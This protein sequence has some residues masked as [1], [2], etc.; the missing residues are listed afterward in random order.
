MK[1]WVKGHA[2]RYP[3]VRCYG[4]N[5]LAGPTVAKIDGTR[6]SWEWLQDVRRF[7]SDAPMLKILNYL[8]NLSNKTGILVSGDSERIGGSFLFPSKPPLRP[9]TNRY[10]GHYIGSVTSAASRYSASR[11]NFLINQP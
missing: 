4:R 7:F 1:P 10:L 3:S 9:T 6:N 8:E 11:E 5:D 2:D